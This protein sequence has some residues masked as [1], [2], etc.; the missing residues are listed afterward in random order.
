MEHPFRTYVILGVLA[1]L[2][3]WLV[4]LTEQDDAAEH[5]S[6]SN[7]IDYYSH[8][9]HKIEMNTEGLPKNELIADSMLHYSGDGATHLQKPVMYLFNQDMPPWIIQS[10]SGI[11]SRN[12]ENL[13]LHGKVHINRTAA[14]K[15]AAMTINTSE[16]RVRLPD[17]YAET[18]EWAEIISPPN[19]TEG[20]GMQATFVKP[21]HLKFL[22]NVKG[23][24]ELR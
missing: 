8:G 9:Y 15:V 17:H 12:G 3:W 4:K 19:R 2:S 1:L 6:T 21:V 10:E 23:R 7:V 11:L 14:R 18:D 22:A 20:V 24:Y 13:Q 16:L 5:A